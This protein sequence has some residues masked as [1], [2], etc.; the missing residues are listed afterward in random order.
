MHSRHPAVPLLLAALL[1]STGCVAVP[2]HPPRAAPPTGLAPAAV[3]PPVPLPEHPAPTPPPPLETLAATEPD[4]HRAE[5]RT[6]RTTTTARTADAERK[7]RRTGGTHQSRPR[8]YDAQAPSSSGRRADRPPAAAPKKKQKRR[9]SV[10]PPKSTPRRPAADLR[11]L[12]RQAGPSGA[13][14]PSVVGLCR[15]MYGS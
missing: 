10:Q 1:L 3:R 14:P 2:H 5:G 12:C 6:T 11:S 8:P 15:D 9:R 4:D 7:E 13:V